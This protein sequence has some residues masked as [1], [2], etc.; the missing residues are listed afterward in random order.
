M[1]TS[2]ARQ[3]TEP[4]CLVSFVIPAHDEAELVPWA[5]A[6]VASQTR[7]DVVEAVV[8]DNA[9]RDATGARVRSFARQTDIPVRLVSEPRLGVA[10]AR[11]RG[12]NSACG[13]LVTFLDADSKAAPDLAE[14]VLQRAAAGWPA[15]CI[16]ITADTGDL[17]DRAFF[18]LMELG[19]QLFGVR[20]QMFYC[21]RDLFWSHQGFK[22]DLRLAEDLEFLHR[23]KCAHVPVCHLH[24]SA[25]A[26]SARRLHTLPLRMA[27]ATTLL[28]WTLA[29]R[30]LGRRWSY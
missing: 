5:L 6:S 27:V 10:R 26:T 13:L 21:D 18:G 20:A 1:P 30:G 9:S 4:G 11:N 3:K 25:I 8:V 7:R 12:A 22:E 16:R 2:L 14:K 15:G 23:L 17:V 24:E 29:H 19:K 28:R